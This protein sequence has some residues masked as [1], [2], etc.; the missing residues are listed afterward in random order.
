MLGEL[1][2]ALTGVTPERA[3]EMALAKLKEV[4]R[5]MTCA[6]CHHLGRQHPDGGAC[7]GLATVNGDRC[8]CQG[9]KRHG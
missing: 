9:F 7:N 1:F 3:K 2:T 8:K 5:E 6:E 4:V